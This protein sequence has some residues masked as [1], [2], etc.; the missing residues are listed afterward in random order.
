M[1]KNILVKLLE[2]SKDHLNH[3]IIVSRLYYVCFMQGKLLLLLLEMSTLEMKTLNIFSH[4][5]SGSSPEHSSAK[6]CFS[7]FT[8]RMS[9]FLFLSAVQTYL[10]RV[11]SG[12]GMS[13]VFKYVVNEVKTVFR[14]FKTCR[15]IDKDMRFSLLLL[16]SGRNAARVP[17]SMTQ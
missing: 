4:A 14:S 17:I 10:V 1:Y 2:T 9:V 6:N 8:W 11:S 16:L 5:A 3:M 7:C 13:W 15:F 12:V